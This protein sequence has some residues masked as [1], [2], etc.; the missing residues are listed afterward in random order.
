MSN[1]R[2]EISRSRIGTTKPPR[3]AAE[4]FVFQLEIRPIRDRTGTEGK[5]AVY[6]GRISTIFRALGVT[7]IAVGPWYFATVW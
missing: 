1:A 3:F 6:F 5:K 2:A 4:A 7:L